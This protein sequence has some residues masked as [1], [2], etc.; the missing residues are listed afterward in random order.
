M[1]GFSEEIPKYLA[2]SD[3][4][5]LPSYREGFGMVLA[6]AAAMGKPVIA[7]R[8]RGSEEAV[9]DGKTGILIPQKDI[10]ALTNALDTLRTND[11]LRSLLGENGR[12]KALNVF[13]DNVVTLKIDN[14]YETLL[15]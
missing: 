12:K 1:K 7:T 15:L 9:D 2:I 14:V 4:L 11:Q 5:V 13:S 6:E 8:T 3:V 10:S